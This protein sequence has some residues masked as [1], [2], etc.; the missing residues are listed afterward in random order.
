MNKAVHAVEL[1][2]RLRDAAE[3]LAE[4][5]GVS[6]DDWIAFAVAQKVGSSEAVAEF[7]K[8]KATGATGRDL[9]YYLDRVP[10]A[11]PMP[12][13]ELPEGWNQSN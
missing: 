11:A 4:M 1:P 2:A 5:E 10:N 12:G 6:V 9:L 8:H 3:R 7:L 13:D